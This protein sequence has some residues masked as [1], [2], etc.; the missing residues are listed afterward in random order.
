MLFIIHPLICHWMEQ[1]PLTLSTVFHLSIFQS[2]LPRSSRSSMPLFTLHPAERSIKST[3][4][5]IFIANGRVFMRISSLSFPRYRFPSRCTS[6]KYFLHFFV[7]FFFH[8]FV[9]S[10][11]KSCF[12]IIRGYSFLN[13]V[14]GY[15][16]TGF[17]YATERK[18][19]YWFDFQ[20]IIGWKMALVFRQG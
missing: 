10:L 5:Y 16:C 18:Y 19:V 2:L 1:S 4:G 20:N 3:H 11:E 8:V 7:I 15:L 17:R 9:M 13:N 12:Q 14:I 6:M